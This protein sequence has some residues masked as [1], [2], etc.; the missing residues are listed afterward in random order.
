MSRHFITVE[1]AANCHELALHGWILVFNEVVGVGAT[2]FAELLL[3][4]MSLSWCQ[5]GTLIVC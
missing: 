2:L 3:N 1:V 4:L 5:I